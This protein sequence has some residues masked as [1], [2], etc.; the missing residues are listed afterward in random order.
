MFARM[1]DSITSATLLEGA[2][3]DHNRVSIFDAKRGKACDLFCPIC[4][5]GLV[6][7]QGGI[8]HWHFAHESGM[9]GIGCAESALHLAVK[10]ELVSLVGKHIYPGL[11]IQLIGVEDE[12]WIGSI[13]RRMDIKARARIGKQGRRKGLPSGTGTLYIEVCVTNRK[14]EGYVGD[15]KSAGLSVVEFSITHKD[16]A[17]R[18]SE[19]PEHSISRII[20]YFLQRKRAYRWLNW[21]NNN[22]RICV[23][24][25]K[26]LN[27]E[28]HGVYA[29]CYLCHMSRAAA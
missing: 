17:A 22:Q 15:I 28:Y 20:R 3:I 5:D 12:A 26:F 29:T 16:I 1:T 8:V 21:Q 9:D 27:F 18:L 4:G 14:D 7:K 6:A 24:C 11:Y 19:N 2:D 23:R 10:R 25:G 13:N